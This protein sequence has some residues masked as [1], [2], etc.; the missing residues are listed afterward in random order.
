MYR[1]ILTL[2]TLRHVTDSYEIGYDDGHTHPPNDLSLDHDWKVLM[3]GP[4]DQ[5]M[6]L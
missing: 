4:L 3:L 1:Y 6:I 2:A 5:T